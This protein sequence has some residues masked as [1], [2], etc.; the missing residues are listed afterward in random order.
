MKTKKINWFKAAAV[1]A[2]RTF[3]QAFL[4]TAGTTAVKL[5]Q[6]D[7]VSAAS[8]AATAAIFSLIT[9]LAGLPEVDA[10]EEE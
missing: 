1:R 2:L 10:E 9:S 7:W 5:D 8:I 3:C 4:A 6:V